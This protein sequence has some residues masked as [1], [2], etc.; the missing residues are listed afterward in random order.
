R[1][2]W[3][4][5]PA[6]ALPTAPETV[7]FVKEASPDDA[8]GFD[9]RTGKLL[10]TFHVVPKPDEPGYDTW[11]KDSAKIA[12]NLSAWC[13]LSADE[14]LGLVYLPFTAPRLRITVAG[15]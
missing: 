15:A 7:G 5:S 6:A 11:G 4:L 8:R 2:M 13:P 12:G 10:W 14:E 3:W 9:V 1:E